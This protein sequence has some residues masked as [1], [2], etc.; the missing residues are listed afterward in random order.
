MPMPRDTKRHKEVVEQ[1]KKRMVGNSYAKGKK[2]NLSQEVKNARRGRGNP[3]FGKKHT[4]ITLDKIAPF[5]SHKG[6]NHPMWKGGISQKYRK[7]LAP[8][9]QPEDCEVCGAFAGKGKMG[10]HF[11]HDH[12]TGKFR[13]WLCGRCNVALGMVKDNSETLIALAEYIKKSR[14]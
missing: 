9:P 6:E 8:R 4:K 11:D 10:I 5:R 12:T 3:F 2:W 1:T 14:I 7:T 13:G